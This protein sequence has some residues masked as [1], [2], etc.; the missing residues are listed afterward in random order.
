MYDVT[1]GQVQVVLDFATEEVTKIVL[2]AQIHTK[3]IQALLSLSFP[4][5]SWVHFSFR[6]MG[7]Y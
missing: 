3:F 6:I 4:L 7:N 5:L 1:C 2:F